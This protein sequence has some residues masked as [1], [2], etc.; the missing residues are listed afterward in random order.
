MFSMKTSITQKLMITFAL[1]IILSSVLFSLSFYFVSM[2]IIDKNV[3]PQFDKAL[4]TSAKDIYNNL[5]NSQAMQ[6]KSGSQN[7]IYTIQNYFTTK[8]K[9]LNLQTA[10]LA[11]VQK[12]QAI[13]LVTDSNSPM[14]PKTT[15][16]VQEAMNNALTSNSVS[17]SDLYSDEYGMH[18]TAYIGLPGSEIV[19]AVG[20]NADFV[21]EKRD[22]INWICIGLSVFIIVTCLVTAYWVSRRITKPIVNLSRIA[23]KMAE[24]DFREDIP[25]KGSDEIALLSYSFRTMTLSL[26][27]MIAEVLKTS[28]H[29]VGDS[30]EMAEKIEDIK[31]GMLKSRESAKN[32]QIGSETI[33][34][35]ATENA[36]AMEEISKGVQHIAT[37]SAEVSEQMCQASKELDAS[38]KLAQATVE[39]INQIEMAS[40]ESLRH[41]QQMN[42]RSAAVTEIVKT[43]NEITK[44]IQI[45]A[46]NAAIEASRAGEHGRGFAVVASEVRSLAEQSSSAVKEIGESLNQIREDS[47]NSVHAMNEVNSEIKAGANKVR[48]A[49][50]AF[51][52]LD[53]WIQH[54][55][56]TMQS[57]SSA[58]QQVS[59]GT[60]EV[61]ASVEE[62]ASIS[63]QSLENIMAISASSES[64]REYMEAFFAKVN[65]LQKQ[66][67]KLRDSVQQFKI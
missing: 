41:M 22:Q 8:I 23:Q 38:N 57:I 40:A 10:Y 60:E 12:D 19:L 15:L 34:S 29:V 63:S 50:Q 43:I 26:K 46:L 62:S 27:E 30:T 9:E 66:A 17:F 25:V 21:K 1:I 4:S 61:T 35:A 7:S 18:K 2:N 32:I 56:M 16:E 59:A 31:S 53:E 28:E 47:I 33:S 52:Q 6:V 44:Q 37:S 42:S 45:L 55:N 5:N 13:V 36:R 54:I 67:D 24:G 49:G 58:T 48:E 3:L 39:Q 64:Q 20:I 11:Q 65:H 14:K 51:Q